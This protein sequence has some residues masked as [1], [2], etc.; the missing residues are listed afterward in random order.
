LG[1]RKIIRPMSECIV[2]IRC[3]V[4][5]KIFFVRRDELAKEEGIPYQLELLPGGTTDAAAIAFTAEGVPAGVISIP[6]RYIHSPVELLDL[7]DAINA[8][9]LLEKATKKITKKIIESV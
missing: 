4:C 8:A 7:R 9:K 2:A 6:T 3:P 5:G 1:E